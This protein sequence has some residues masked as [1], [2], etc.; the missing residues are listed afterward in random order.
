[1]EATMGEPLLEHSFSKYL[2]LPKNTV[3]RGTLLM[4]CLLGVVQYGVVYV[5]AVVVDELAPYY[6]LNRSAADELFDMLNY[7]ACALSFV[8]G[9]LYDKLG[10]T[11]AMVIGTCVGALP[12]LLLLNWSWLVGSV[13]VLIGLKICY[14]IFGMALSFFQVIAT[15]APLE[16]FPVQYLGAVSAAVQVSTS[17]G[18]T[19]QSA[20]FLLLKAHFKDF[21]YAYYLYM[22]TCTV[23]CG[24]LMAF[25]FWENGRILH[26]SKTT[27]DTDNTDSLG[28]QLMSVSFAYDCLLFYLGVGFVFSYL[29]AAGILNALV[30]LGASRATVAFGIY[31]A[32]ARV[33]CNLALDFTR[34]KRCGG[35][36]TYIALSL[37]SLATGLL[38]VAVA[39]PSRGSVIAMNIF[40]SFGAGG[41]LGITPAALRL[42]FGSGS[43]GLIYGLLYVLTSLGIPT[44][45][46]LLPRPTQSWSTYCGTGY[47]VLP[48]ACRCL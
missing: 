39:A 8:P 19:I 3:H 24:V 5:F 20:V 23:G 35:P 48:V 43:L 21:V 6:G 14:L 1:M 41:L 13:D 26:R 44:W 4:A 33:V 9:L 27:I 37:I 11:K 45:G 28:S 32:L 34:T 38:A 12:I 22:L 18:A 10:A 47:A 25:A 31:G 36:M 46:S 40:C 29:D 2:G 16:A 42:S 7:G 30:G 17:L 15:F